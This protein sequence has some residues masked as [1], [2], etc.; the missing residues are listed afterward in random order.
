MP[1][2]IEVAVLNGTSTPGLAGRVGDD[3]QASGFKLGTVTSTRRQY[4]QTVVMYSPGQKRAAT[5]VAP[6]LG[7]TPIQPIDSV[8]RARRPTRTVVIAGSDRAKIPS[9]GGP[10]P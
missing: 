7:V 10:K 6:V 4:Q 2:D 3:V 1:A 5:K 9:S 8:I